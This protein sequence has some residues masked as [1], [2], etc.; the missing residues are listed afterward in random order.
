MCKKDTNV[1]VC[2]SADLTIKE[3]RRSF[4]SYKKAGNHDEV[5]KSTRTFFHWKIKTI[6]SKIS[7]DDL[8]DD[9]KKEQEIYNAIFTSHGYDFGYFGFKTREDAIENALKFA[10]RNGIEL[11]GYTL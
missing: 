5:T 8:N 10:E 2:N 4:T 1:A 11:D 9:N 6:A 7:I 3:L